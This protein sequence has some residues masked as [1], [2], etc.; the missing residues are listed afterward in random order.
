ML[1]SNARE[2]LNWWLFS[3]YGWNGNGFVKKSSEI[4]IVTVARPLGYGATCLGKQA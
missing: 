4:Q 3:L 2:N 1:E